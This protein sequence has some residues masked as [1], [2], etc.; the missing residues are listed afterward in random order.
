MKFFGKEMKELYMV[1]NNRKVMA[2]LDLT[3]LAAMFPSKIVGLL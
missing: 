2:N 1:F 3:T